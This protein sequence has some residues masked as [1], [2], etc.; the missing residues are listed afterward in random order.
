MALVN[1]IGVHQ[2][3]R[4]TQNVIRKVYQSNYDVRSAINEFYIFLSSFETDQLSKTLHKTLTINTPNCKLDFPASD[5]VKRWS[6]PHVTDF[7][8]MKTL[9]MSLLDRA[10][11]AN[12]DHALNFLHSSIKNLPAEFFLQ[13]PYLFKSLFECLFLENFEKSVLAILYDLTKS[14]QARMKIRTL[15]RTCEFLLEEEDVDEC[16][17]SVPAYC[18]HLIMTIMS[19]MKEMD[20]HSSQERLNVYFELLSSVVNV[21]KGSQGQCEKQSILREMTFLAMFYREQ[22]QST[23]E[24]YRSRVNY[25]TILQMIAVV[26]SCRSTSKDDVEVIKCSLVDGE[27]QEVPIWRKELEISLMDFSFREAMPDVYYE[28][29]KICNAE[30]NVRLATMV[31]A[32]K[33]R[34]YIFRF[35]FPR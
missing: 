20:G 2:I 21:L 34:K 1:I 23:R 5:Y 35:F 29:Y 16:Q 12:M 8:E 7:E 28:V 18:Y 4:D 33:V 15:T 27:E 11:A 31:N 25:L 24:N 14:L 32:A 6:R 10:N 17:L 26:A 3:R 22:Y 19:A 30:E 13:P 9:K